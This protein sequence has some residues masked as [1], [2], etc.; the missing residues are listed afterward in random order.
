L[1]VRQGALIPLEWVVECFDDA[2]ESTSKF[3]SSCPHAYFV[4]VQGVNVVDRNELTYQLKEQFGLVH[5]CLIGAREHFTHRL[6]RG[7]HDDGDT[8]LGRIQRF[9]TRA[10]AALPDESKA[11]LLALV[12]Q[13]LA[14]EAEAAEEPTGPAK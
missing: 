4:A 1:K 8:I 5:K 2:I 7:P 12:E 14:Q 11:I 9:Y 13:E 10:A 6:R 3:T